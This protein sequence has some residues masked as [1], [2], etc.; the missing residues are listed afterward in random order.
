MRAKTLNFERGMEPS[1]SLKIGAESLRGRE[2]RTHELVKR[3]NGMD[4]DATDQ[5][6]ENI[7]R[8]EKCL[9]EFIG[10]GVSPKDITIVFDQGKFSIKVLQVIKNQWGVGDFLTKEDADFPQN[11]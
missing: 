7:G 5:V 6:V 4:D 1:K 8:Y 9:D 11:S 2:S 10:F 3:I